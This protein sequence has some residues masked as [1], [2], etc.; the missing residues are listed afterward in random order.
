M[1]ALARRTG[2]AAFFPTLRRL[3]HS[4]LVT[5]RRGLYCLTDRGRHEVMLGCAVRASVVRA[6][7]A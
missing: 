2:G 6:F 5:R 1:R 3:E 4:G 7:A